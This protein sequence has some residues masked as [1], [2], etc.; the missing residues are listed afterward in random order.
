M[1]L[2]FVEEP[3]GC[4]LNIQAGGAINA[5]H[6]GFVSIGKTVFQYLQ[7]CGLKPLH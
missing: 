6:I 4:I 7:N 3:K 5:I 1:A 2:V